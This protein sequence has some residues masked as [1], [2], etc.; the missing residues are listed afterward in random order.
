MKRNLK[1]IAGTANPDLAQGIAAYLEL[2]LVD[3]EIERFSDGEIKVQ[4]LEN[5]R[6]H[7]VFVIQPTCAPS[8]D[9]LMELLIIIDALRRASAGRITAVVPY[10]GYARQ[11][12][13]D[14]P[15]VPITSKLVANLL[16]TAGVNRILSVDLHADQIQGF[17]DIPFDHLYSMPVTAEY[18]K[19]K[20]DKNKVVVV[21]PDAGGTE[22]ARAFA[23]RIGVSRIAIIDKRRPRANVAEVMN[24]VG[25]V[26][27]LNAIIVD[28]IVD[29]AGTLTKAAAALKK[30]GAVSVLAA[31]A[32]AVLSGPAFERIMNSDIEELVVTDSI[33]LVNK[34]C[35][36]I[37]VLT[38]SDLIGEAIFR[39]HNEQSLG[40]LFI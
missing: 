15:R 9:N 29:T 18:L 38:L 8:N 36:K 34:E 27:G 12:R 23:K 30:N 2:P 4:I 25:K 21:S 1:L 14:R 37:T 33:P 32:H 5:V 26:K 6:G 40:P 24:V 3:R 28:D 19:K 39:I 11:D 22:R 13:K 31:C 16:T 20:L 7:D 35:K 17:F 10:Y